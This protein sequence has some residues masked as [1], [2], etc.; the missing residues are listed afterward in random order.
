MKGIILLVT[1]LTL[2]CA[3]ALAETCADQQPTLRRNSP[4]N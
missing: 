4:W 3:V 1:L 2:S